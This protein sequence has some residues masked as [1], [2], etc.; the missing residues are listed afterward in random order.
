MSLKSGRG[1]KRRRRR[2][3]RRRRH[4]FAPNHFYIPRIKTH[5]EDN[6]LHHPTYIYILTHTYDM[7]WMGGGGC[8][9][10]ELQDF[11]RQQQ[12]QQ[13]LWADSLRFPEEANERTNDGEEEEEES[14]AK[15]N[16]YKVYKRTQKKVV[17]VVI[18]IIIIII[19]IKGKYKETNKNS[20]RKKERG[21]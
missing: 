7:G 1:R 9:V 17:V 15:K 20:G 11:G 14:Q 6:K 18:I 12:Q 4:S 21:E 2:R 3:R 8:A 5:S 13:R 19:I 10:S 16:I